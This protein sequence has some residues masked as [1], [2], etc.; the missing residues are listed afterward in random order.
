[1]ADLETEPKPDIKPA[2]TDAE[3]PPVV[4]DPAKTARWRLSRWRPSRWRPS[5]WA[6]TVAGLALLLVV[7]L[8]GGTLLLLHNNRVSEAAAQRQAATETADR[9]ALGLSTVSSDTARQQLDGLIQ[10]STGAFRDQISGTA[11]A[12][13]QLVQMG[14][15]TSRG[16]VTGVGLEKIEP[17]TAIALVGVRATVANSQAP[18]GVQRSH[19]I[20]VHLQREG[21][22]WLASNVVFV[23]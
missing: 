16:V 20:A 3:G 11:A 23:P 9:V 1:M 8:V 2:G 6:M 13:T 12:F 21:G 18:Q 5:R 22:R 15:V 14:K 7:L 4:A 10:D 19:R 17:G